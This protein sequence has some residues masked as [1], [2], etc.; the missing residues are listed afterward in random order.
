MLINR[1]DLE[2]MLKVMDKFGLT[3]PYDGIAVEYN[4]HPAGY[5]LSISFGQVL[6]DVVCKVSVLID[7]ETFGVQD[8]S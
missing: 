1:R 4:D 2:Y 6:N 5:D 3:M 7:G 8:D